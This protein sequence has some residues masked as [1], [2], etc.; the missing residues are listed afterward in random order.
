L[1]TFF[2]NK[3]R[4]KNK[5]KRKNVKNVNKIKKR[6]KHFYIYAFVLKDADFARKVE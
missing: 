2:K 6:K 5:K 3:K 1:P 4:L